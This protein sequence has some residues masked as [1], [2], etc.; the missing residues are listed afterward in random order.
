LPKGDRCLDDRDPPVIRPPSRATKRWSGEE[1]KPGDPPACD[2][3][4]SSVECRFAWARHHF[5]TLRP[6]LAA[7]EFR[8]IALDPANGELATKAASLSL[9]SFNML[10]THA[11]PPRPACFQNIEDDAKRY[12]A[13]HCAKTP[14]PNEELC[15]LLRRIER[16]IARLEIESMVKQADEGPPNDSLT[17]YLRAA[18]GYRRLY[19]EH[20]NLTLPRHR[21]ADARCEELLYNAY[22]AYRAARRPDEAYEARATLLDPRNGLRD[23]DLA[24]RVAAEP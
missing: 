5:V 10:G 17:L 22:R 23:T 9:E 1:Q 13:L 18:D 19:D 2:P 15:L 14:E 24:K 11:E 4:E 6:D 12:L 20:C 21:R 7:R 16:D 3:G 8:E